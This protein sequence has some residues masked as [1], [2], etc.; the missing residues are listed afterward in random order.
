MEVPEHDQEEK[1]KMG[2]GGSGD[3]YCSSQWSGVLGNAEHLG[4][5]AVFWVLGISGTYGLV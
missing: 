1:A 2:E 5:T 3:Q 4:C